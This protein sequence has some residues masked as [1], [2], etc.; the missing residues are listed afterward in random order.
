MG[1]SSY[2]WAYVSVLKKMICVEF[3]LR[4]K[5]GEDELTFVEHPSSSVPM[6]TTIPRDEAYL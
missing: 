3:A 6:V 1:G 4:Q 2:D 5:E